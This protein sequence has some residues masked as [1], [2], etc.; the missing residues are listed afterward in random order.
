[1][2]S[3]LPDGNVCESSEPADMIELGPMWCVRAPTNFFGRVDAGFCAFLGV[4][5]G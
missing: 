1:M 5:R 2:G 3:E 4:G